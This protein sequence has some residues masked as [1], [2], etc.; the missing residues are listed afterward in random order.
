MI[1]QS[2]QRKSILK[3]LI[4]VSQRLHP[5]NPASILANEILDE[6]YD[7]ESNLLTLR[8]HVIVNHNDPATFDM[9]PEQACK[10]RKNYLSLMIEELTE[11]LDDVLARDPSDYESSTFLRDKIDK[12]E[13]NLSFLKVKNRPPQVDIDVV[14]RIPIE[15]VFARLDGKRDPYGRPLCPFHDDTQA[16]NFKIY[17]SNNSCYCFACGKGGTTIDLVMHTLSCNINESL[18]FLS[19]MVY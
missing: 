1:S 15:E 19:N 12:A 5:S 16:G 8:H 7:L 11:E 14:R 6:E 3:V 10:L 13:S 18:K 2:S 4:T 9:T 17:K